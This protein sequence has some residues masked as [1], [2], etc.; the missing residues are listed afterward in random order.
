M[1]IHKAR[2]KKQYNLSLGGQEDAQEGL[3]L[4]I[5]LI[6]EFQKYF[7]IRHD[8]MIQCL[9]CKKKKMAEAG[10]EPPELIIDLSEEMPYTQEKLCTKIAVE[11]YIKRNIQIPRDYICDFCQS[12]N[13]SGACNI[14]QIY[15]LTRLSEI[16]ILLFKKYT[17]KTKRYFPM[18][19]D[20]DGVNEHLKYKIIAQVEHYGTRAGGHY[21]ARCLREK[22]SQMHARRAQKI[23]QHYSDPTEMLEKNTEMASQKQGVFQLDDMVANFC[24]DGFQPT[25]NTYMVFYHLC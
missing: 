22:P 11:N 5:D 18:E 25:E 10:I 3:V 20:F 19:L 1:A 9:V 7:Y 14:L 12:K 16:I 4:L 15:S 17:S 23:I 21:N 8:C 13:D 24:L 6:P 2:A